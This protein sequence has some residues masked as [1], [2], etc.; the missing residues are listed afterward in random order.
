MG[1]LLFNDIYEV[2]RF[3]RGISW[4]PILSLAVFSIF[5]YLRF[6]ETGGFDGI[7]TSFCF[8][9]WWFGS[10]K[11]NIILRASKH[12]FYFIFFGG[13]NGPYFWA[14]HFLGI[15]KCSGELLNYFSFFG[16]C[17]SI[18]FDGDG[19]TGVGFVNIFFIT[20]FHFGRDL[21]DIT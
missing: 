4:R 7:G 12:A 16:N 9:P 10:G 13:W 5:F 3:R 14:P 21:L 6:L 18:S 11:V 8:V 1:F 19:N 20:V 15:N 2:M 17:G